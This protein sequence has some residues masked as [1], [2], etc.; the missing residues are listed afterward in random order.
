V[1]DDFNGLVYRGLNRFPEPRVWHHTFHFNGLV[2]RGLGKVE[3]YKDI[4][5]QL[6]EQKP[7]SASSSFQLLLQFMYGCICAIHATTN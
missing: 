4:K 7:T 1:F 6:S 5:Q 3:S 2:Y